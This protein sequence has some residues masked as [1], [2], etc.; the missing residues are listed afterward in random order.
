MGTLNL[1]VESPFIL[2]RV[3]Y[4]LVQDLADAIRQANPDM[5]PEEAT[6]TASD[7]L[8]RHLDAAHGRTPEKPYG[9]DTEGD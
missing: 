9:A 1:S 6:D 3:I 4:G 2:E 7:R 5:T 8:R